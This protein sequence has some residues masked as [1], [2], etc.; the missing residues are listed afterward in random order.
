MLSKSDLEHI[1]EHFEITDN[2]DRRELN[3]RRFDGLSKRIAVM[4]TRIR[5]IENIVIKLSENHLTHIANDI[6]EL[7]AGV[8]KLLKKDKVDI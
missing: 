1:G 5:N 2:Q 3:D 4:D 6:N 7:K 8:A